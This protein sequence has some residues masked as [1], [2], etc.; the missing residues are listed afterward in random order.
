MVIT[1]TPPVSTVNGVHAYTLWNVNRNA[2]GT[3]TSLQLRNPYGNA[4]GSANGYSDANANDAMV[5][6][7]PA[8]V[9]ADNGGRVNWGTAG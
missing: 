5:T 7:T 6:L 2:A 9:F 8:Q 4:D 1:L 3:V